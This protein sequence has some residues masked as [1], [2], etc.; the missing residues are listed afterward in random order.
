MICKKIA[1]GIV[2][3][4]LLSVNRKKTEAEEITASGQINDY[5]YFIF[6]V[7]TELLCYVYYKMH[8]KNMVNSNCPF[9]LLN[10]AL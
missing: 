3:N 7:N 4:E 5:T 6:S 1:V 2:I 10:L 8:I 9:R